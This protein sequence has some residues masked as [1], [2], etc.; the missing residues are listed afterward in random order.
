[1]E[2]IHVLQVRKLSK[3][4]GRNTKK[5]VRKMLVS[6]LSNDLMRSINWTG[7]CGKLAFSKLK[8][9]EIQRM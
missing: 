8:C 6:L 9:C 3:I 7:L 5:A 1:M 2:W 4:G